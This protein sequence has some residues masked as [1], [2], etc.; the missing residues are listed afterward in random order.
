MDS[1]VQLAHANGIHLYLTLHNGDASYDQ[2]YLT[3]TARQ[4]AYLNNFLIPMVMRYKGCNDIFGI[5]IMNEIDAAVAG[6]TGNWSSS[7]ATW[8]QAQTMISNFADAIHAADPDRLCTC[9]TGWHSWN[10][11]SNFKGLGLD[12]YDY[13]L[14][15]D[16]MAMPSAASLNMD[17]PIYIGESGQGTSIESDALQN[18]A[19]IDGLTN[20]VANNYAGLG[21]W[22]YEYAG[23]YA[24]SIAYSSP[25]YFHM[26]NDDGSWRAVCTTIQDWNYPG[27]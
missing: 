13:H 9:T 5:D 7:G 3:S 23:A 24:A 16:T 1:M 19:E 8:A 10:N 6:D 2:D 27:N 18:T 26:L 4:Q 14:Y 12:F 15:A 17:K 21:I 11:I 20:T 22:A 25:D